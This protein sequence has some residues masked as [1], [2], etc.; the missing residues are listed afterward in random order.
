[1]DDIVGNLDEVLEQ[2]RLTKLAEN[3][4][5]KDIRRLS[6][7]GRT[8]YNYA[9]TEEDIINYTECIIN[10][11][12]HVL[13]IHDENEPHGTITSNDIMEGRVEGTLYKELKDYNEQFKDVHIVTSLE[14]ADKS[15][16]ERKIIPVTEY[17][18]IPNNIEISVESSS[19]MSTKEENVTISVEEQNELQETEIKEQEQISNSYD[20]NTTLEQELSEETKEVENITEEEFKDSS[21]DIIIEEQPK[22]KKGLFGKKKNKG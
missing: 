10:V 4:F 7:L 9:T 12:C 2:Y 3:K 19:D 8:L 6:V 5:S 22:K 16:E 13:N 21:S 15:L 1:M 18:G 11:A 20:E 17:D 14:E